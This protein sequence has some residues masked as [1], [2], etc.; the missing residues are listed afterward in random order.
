M[1]T[2]CF[3]SSNRSVSRRR[4]PASTRPSLS[5]PCSSFI[6]AGSSTGEGERRKGKNWE[7]DGFKDFLDQEEILKIMIM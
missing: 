6:V 3:K 2:S 1:A 5:A 4:E 7:W